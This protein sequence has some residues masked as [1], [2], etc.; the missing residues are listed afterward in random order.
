MPRRERHE[1]EIRETAAVAYDELRPPAMAYPPAEEP[2]G[3]SAFRYGY[4]VQ[5]VRDAGGR[6][7]LRQIP[8]TLDDYLHPREGD[9]MTQGNPHERILTP[10]ADLLRRWLEKIPEVGVF[11][12]VLFRWGVPDLP[13]QAPDVAVV[14]GLGRPKA[15]AGSLDCKALGVSPC[16]AIE[17][18]SP[19]H[20]EIREKDTRDK[21]RIYERAGVTEYL[22]VDPAGYG[23]GEPFGLIGYRLDASGRYR[24]LVTDARGAIAS[25][26]T[27]LLFVPDAEH[28]VSVEVIATGERLLYSDEVDVALEAAEERARAE[29]TA[30]RDAEERARAEAAARRDA[31]QRATEAEAE[32]ARLRAEIAR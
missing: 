6:E 10:L 31:E 1:S 30:R 13:A 9:L 26:T 23:R 27:G 32:L 21:V 8:L 7:E 19:T 25:E 18:V 12:D 3:P 17:V 2:P 22:I 16:L 28:G 14:R 11:S 24:Q 20:K 4:R 5:R 15:V 29:A